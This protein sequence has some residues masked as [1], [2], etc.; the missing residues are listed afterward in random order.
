MKIQ[1]VLVLAMVGSAAAAN[2]RKR[3]FKIY[4]R[5]EVDSIEATRS[6]QGG[7]NQDDKNPA[8]PLASMSMAS[9]MSMAIQ[10][11]QGQPG[12]PGGNAKP[13]KNPELA[14]PLASMSMMSSM[15][16]AM[17]A[18]TASPVAATASPVAAITSSA[19]T[20]MASMSMETLATS[21]PVAMSMPAGPCDF[22]VGKQINLTYE[23][24]KGQDCESVQKAAAT[25]DASN[26]YCSSVQA[27][28]QLCCPDA[29]AA[30][31]EATTTATE[32]SSTESA[33]TESTGAALETSTSSTEMIE[34]PSP[35]PP[36]ANF[37]APS[38]AMTMETTLAAFAVAGAIMLV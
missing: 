34:P 32:P 19:P 10:G 25:I 16:M 28:E 12:Q 30:T 20:V 3:V 37:G 2:K 14:V 6:L 1:S 29:P 35:T 22:C 15:S 17:A 13:D 23:L 36:T 18:P 4:S 5:E 31:T 33:S 7:K 9:S 11:E 21:A 26:Q 27:A 38:G 24:V 8:A